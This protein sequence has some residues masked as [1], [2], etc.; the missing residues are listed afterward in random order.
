MKSRIAL[1]AAILAAMA[2]LPSIASATPKDDGD[3]KITICH[4]TEGKN[5][6]VVITVD[7]A[8]F[9]GAGANDHTH[10]RSKDGRVDVPYVGGEC[11]VPGG[12]GGGGGGDEPP[13][14]G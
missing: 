8:A 12:G 3:H 1:A 6:Y 11:L 13:V 5:P 10:H 7:V 9:D 2:V 14:V 4:V